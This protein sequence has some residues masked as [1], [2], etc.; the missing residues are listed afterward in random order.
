MLL[1]PKIADRI[2]T[3]LEANFV[4][5]LKLEILRDAILFKN[6]SL[7]YPF[8]KRTILNFFLHY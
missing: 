1:P 8:E 2:D 5:N 3:A 6:V 7:P 4:L